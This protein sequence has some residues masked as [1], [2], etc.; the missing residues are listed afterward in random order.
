PWIESCAEPESFSGPSAGSRSYQ[1]AWLIPLSF[2]RASATQD[3]G[4]HLG[5]WQILRLSLR[6]I[7]VP[8]AS[9]EVM[10]QSS[11]ATP[12]QEAARG[13]SPSCR[14]LRRLAGGRGRGPD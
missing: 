10:I 1:V 14:F 6:A 7:R 8:N 13:R 5:G 2:K 11:P 4:Q 12:C 3:I 9:G